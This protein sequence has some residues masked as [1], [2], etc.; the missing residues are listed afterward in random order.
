MARP[1]PQ[2]YQPTVPPTEFDDWARWIDDELHRI[3][4]ALSANPVTMAV[5]SKDV[6]RVIA[7][8]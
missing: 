3:A 4:E 5:K 2:V 7:A 8:P 1:L 6:G